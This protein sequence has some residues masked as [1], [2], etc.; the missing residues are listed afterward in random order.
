M[1]MVA[2]AAGA[3]D[4]ED[5]PDV[6]AVARLTGSGATGGMGDRETSEEVST[7]TSMGMGRPQT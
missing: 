2:E 6:G 3:A 5:G 4:T 1:F 7:V